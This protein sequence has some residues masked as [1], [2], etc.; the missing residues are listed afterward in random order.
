MEFAFHPAITLTLSS[1]QF[2]LWLVA[3]GLI[4]P[5]KYKHPV[6]VLG[7]FLF[8]L[9][10]ISASYLPRASS[11][12]IMV[13]FGVVVF[14]IQLLFR[15]KWYAKLFI[16]VAVQTLMVFTELL[17]FPFVPKNHPFSDLPLSNQITLN[18]VYLFV[19]VMLL[20]S[21]VLIV[22]Q[23]RRRRQGELL[24]LQS[25]LFLLFPISQYV[26]FSGWFISEPPFLLVSVPF[27]LL[28]FLLFLAS[29]IGLVIA[30]IA[31]SRS[32]AL[33]AQNELLQKQ[34]FAQQE[35]YSALTE[36]YEDIRRMRHDIDNHL[37]TIKALLADGNTE[38]AV[39][40]ADEVY[41]ADLFAPKSL[42]GCENTVVAS[43]L[44]HR[45]KE[46]Y[47]RKVSLDL[48]VSVPGSL[49][50]SNLD[51]ICAVGNLLDNAA[52]AC[53]GIPDP[54]IHLNIRFLDPYLQMTVRNPYLEESNK[55]PR[56]IPELSRGV[57]QEILSQLV[58][59][60]DGH[61]EQNPSDGIYTVHL[62][63]KNIAPEEPPPNST[64]YVTHTF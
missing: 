64:D 5:E 61:M 33:Q 15:G 8:L 63:L 29:D 57:G 28:S 17:M 31:T 9:A 11:S 3:V 53:S 42:L 48:D 6:T 34:V 27:A 1:I 10:F 18:L 43:F 46:L 60:Y 50:I 25:L 24:S 52:E 22:R 38:E 20:A 35:H 51:L 23:V 54:V 30:M 32:A 59:R 7:V 13:G 47:G 14:G 12:R 26:A 56:R 21:F 40:Y 45:Q 41:K 58:R 36:H 62:F 19:H 49:C 4:L 39:R 37:Y 2:F 44:L 16:A 55:K